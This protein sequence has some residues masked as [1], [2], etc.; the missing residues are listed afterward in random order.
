[1]KKHSSDYQPKNTL[2]SSLD[3]SRKDYMDV[4]VRLLVRMIHYIEELRKGWGLQSRSAVIERLL[5][6][7]S[8]KE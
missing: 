6:I 5:E 2:D 1:M 8:E 7:I 4:R 3:N